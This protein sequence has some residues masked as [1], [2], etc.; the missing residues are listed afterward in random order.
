MLLFIVCFVECALFG[1]GAVSGLPGGLGQLQYDWRG[2]RGWRFVC[3]VVVG[4]GSE[5]LIYDGR[6]QDCFVV[7]ETIQVYRALK[8][9]LM[10]G[11]VFVGVVGILCFESFPIHHRNLG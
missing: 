1:R 8:V 4:C 7:L 3:S 6:H 9:C 11:M 2:S 5:E 10:E